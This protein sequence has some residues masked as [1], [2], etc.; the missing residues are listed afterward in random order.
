M[1]LQLKQLVQKL[2]AKTVD[3]VRGDAIAALQ[4]YQA[5]WDVVFLDPPFN[6]NLFES[7][8]KAARA[9]VAEDGFIYL[10]APEAFDAERLQ[11]LGLEVFRYLKAG[12]VHAHLLKRQG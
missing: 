5:H 4:A 12:A 9:A 2:D 1:K 6:G 11:P 7:A 3:V 10:E 8:L